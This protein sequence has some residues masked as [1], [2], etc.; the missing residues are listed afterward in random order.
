MAPQAQRPIDDKRRTSER[1]RSN[2]FIPQDG[3]VVVETPH[4]SRCGA[5]FSK[6][7]RAFLL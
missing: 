4:S 3:D 7:A 6:E 5:T 2:D 1:E